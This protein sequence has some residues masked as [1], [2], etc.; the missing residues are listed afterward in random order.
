[1]VIASLNQASFLLQGRSFAGAARNASPDSALTAI[2]NDSGSMA[3]GVASV[4]SARSGLAHSLF[5]VTSVD[6]TRMKVDLFERVGK[7]LG[8]DRGDYD[9]AFAYGSAV[10]RAVKQLK[11][12][13]N[14]HLIL[15]GLEK[16]LG[17]DKLGLSLDAVVDAMTDASGDGARKLDAALRAE[18]SDLA[19]KD[20]AR[21]SFTFDEIGIYRRVG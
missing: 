18:T 20:N 1:M 2:A 21:Q 10:K 5:S 7:A 6:V 19:G 11:Q 4:P 9:T 14:S 8:V 13:P 15:M 17:L 3:Q 16:E 12:Q